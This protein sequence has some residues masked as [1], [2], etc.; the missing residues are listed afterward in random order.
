MIIASAGL[1]ANGFLV[2]GVDTEWYEELCEK[3]AAVGQRHWQVR[4]GFAA[5]ADLVGELGRTFNAL[6][7]GLERLAQGPADERQHAVKNALAGLA[8]TAYVLAESETTAPQVRQ[9]L[10]AIVEAVRR[11]EQQLSEWLKAAGANH[12]Q[13]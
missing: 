4:V 6:A 2:V 7:E 8:A 10:Q 11:I 13:S 9:A 12:P 1:G 5:R 3:L